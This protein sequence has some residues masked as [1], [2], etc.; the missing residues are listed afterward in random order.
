MRLRIF[1][2][3]A[4]TALAL[5]GCAT[6]AFVEERVAEID[7]RLDAQDARIAELSRTSREA[8]ARAEDAGVLARGKFLYAVVLTEEGVRFESEEAKLSPDAEARLNRLASDLRAEN[9][10]VYLEIQGHTDAT[11]APD[12]NQWLGQQRA[13]AVRRHLHR[14]GVALD[15]MATISYGEDAPAA[16]NATPEGRAQNRRVEIVVLE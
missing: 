15:R 3:A 16:D 8:L 12:Y 2:V 13:D 1:T 14:Q 7:A 9:R 11:G 6:K 4:M 10:S 5:S